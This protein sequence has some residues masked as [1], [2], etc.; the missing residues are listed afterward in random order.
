MS[1][2]LFSTSGEEVIQRHLIRPESVSSSSHL[3]QQP[4]ETLEEAYEVQRCVQWIREKKVSH[5]AL[6]F[7]D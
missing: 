2:A 4:E 1:S 3:N 6:Q 5:V 7:P